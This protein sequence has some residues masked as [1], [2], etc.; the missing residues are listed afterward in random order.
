MDCTGPV[1]AQ[2]RIDE[3]FLTSGVPLDFTIA[4]MG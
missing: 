2:K 4:L 1:L 3:R